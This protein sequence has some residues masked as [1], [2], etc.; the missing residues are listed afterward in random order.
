MK[1]LQHMG[2]ACKGF[3]L[4]NTINNA[5]L[6][7]RSTFIPL[8]NDFEPQQ[9][10]QSSL[11]PLIEVP[12]YSVY[13]KLSSLNFRKA[14]GSDGI[15]AGLMKENVDLLADPVRDIPNWSFSEGRLLPSWKTAD[16]V[17]IPKQKPVKNVNKD[18]RPISLTP[19][20][21]KI[22][23]E[24]VVEEHVRPAM[25]KKIGDG[26]LGSI[27]KSSTTH[28]LLSMIHSWTKHTDGTCSTV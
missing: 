10:D 7:P 26:Q 24:F 20:L 25:L 11:A 17:P 9:E 1:S 18:L 2:E 12:A 3:D 19:V 5:F 16:I 23:K 6:S 4:A 27:P 22:A 28:A 21:F 13:M 14:S 15:P 8:P